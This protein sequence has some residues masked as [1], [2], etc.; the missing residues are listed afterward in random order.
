[1]TNDQHVKRIMVMTERELLIELLTSP[2]YMTDGY[3]RV[4]RDAIIKRATELGVY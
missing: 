1:M 4:F 2:E 3:Y